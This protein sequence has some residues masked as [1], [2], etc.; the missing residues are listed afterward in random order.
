MSQDSEK[1]WFLHEAFQRLVSEFD[2]KTESNCMGLIRAWPTQSQHNE[3]SS[4][5]SSCC[6]FCRLPCW[7]GQPLAKSTTKKLLRCWS[8]YEPDDIRSINS[9][10]VT[11]IVVKKYVRRINH[12]INRTENWISTLYPQGW[13]RKPNNVCYHFNSQ[14]QPHLPG[15]LRH[16]PTMNTGHLQKQHVTCHRTLSSGSL[17]VTADVTCSLFNHDSGILKMWKPCPTPT[18]TPHPT[19]PDC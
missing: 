2:R 10:T 17:K 4:S 1:T 9:S 14:P 13:E 18:S 12:S 6:I 11:L 15:C 3:M 8:F 16:P 7:R 19:P 5:L